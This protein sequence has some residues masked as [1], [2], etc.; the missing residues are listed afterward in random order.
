MKRSWGR[1]AIQDDRDRGYAIKRRRAVKKKSKHWSTGWVLDQGAEPH[2]VGFAWAGW[3]MSSPIRQNPINPSGI[4]TFAQLLDE[5][6]GTDYDGTSVRA[7]AKVLQAA[8]QISSYQWTWELQPAVNHILEVGPLVIGINWYEKMSNP[9]REGYITPSG[10]LQ[11]GHAI[12]CYG[13]D[14]RKARISLQNS[15]GPN[16]G[17]D[18]K[19]Y[20]SFEDFEQ[21]LSEDGECCTAIES[22]WE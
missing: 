13:A 10:R 12:L 19:C 5:W 11:G 8:G 2:C 9:T 22:R 18:G 20:L 7:G 16:W 14:T 17:S 15:W 1:F 21:L 4:Y 6:E 3:L